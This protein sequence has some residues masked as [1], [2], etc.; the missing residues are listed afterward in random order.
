MAGLEVVILVIEPSVD[1][2]VI[3]FDDAG[4]SVVNECQVLRWRSRQRGKRR[5]G[6]L[7]LGVVPRLPQPVKE[8]RPMV[9]EVNVIGLLAR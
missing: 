5:F 2:S 3:D 1:V 6:F 8:E 7:G 4:H 9:M